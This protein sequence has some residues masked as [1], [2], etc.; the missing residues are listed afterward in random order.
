MTGPHNV[1]EARFCEIMR[2]QPARLRAPDE[3]YDRM[4][5]RT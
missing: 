4:G 2:A 5:L 1:L 3:Q